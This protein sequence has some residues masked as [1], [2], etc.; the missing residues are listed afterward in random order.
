MTIEI[1]DGGLTTYGALLRRRIAGRIG[2]SFAAGGMYVT[3]SV[4]DTFTKPESYRIDGGGDD[5]HIT[6]SDE[7]GLYY[8]IGKFLHSACWT[9]ESFTPHATDGWVSPDCPFRCIY[10][11]V[12]F[13]NWYHRATREELKQY[14]E[15]LMLYG[16]NTIA[17]I[18]PVLNIHSFEEPLY[19]DAVEKIRTVYA[20]AKDVGM[21]TMF[22]VTPNQ[23]LLSAPHDWDADLSYD[24]EGIYRGWLGRNLCPNKPGA[25]EYLRGIWLRCLEQFFDIGIDYVITC[26]YDEGGCGCEKCKPWGANGFETLSRL[27]ARDVKRLYPDAKFIYSTWTFDV[28]TD[29]QEYS[30]LYHRLAAGEMD[31]VDYLMTDA[32]DTYP[33]YVLEHPV[34]RP[35]VNFPEISMWKLWPWGGFGATPMPRRFEAIWDSAKAVLSGG[36]PYTE[37]LYE[38]ISKIQ[39]IGYY[40]DKNARYTD[41][42][43]EYAAYQFGCEVAEDAVRLMELIE[44]N[45]VRVAHVEEPDFAAAEQAWKLAQSIDVRMSEQCKTAWRWRVLYIR[46]VLDGKRYAMYRSLGMHGE[47]DLYALRHDTKGKQLLSHD[48]EAQA[49]YREL[50]EIYHCVDHDNGSNQ[51]TLPVVQGAM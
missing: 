36:M 46:A 10:F 7:R 18:V 31:Y 41:I 25:V 13:Y 33:R 30:T 6:G 51:W 39:F 50:R 22:G 44:E 43:R 12:H 47:E 26:P 34:I 29:Q 1:K 14:L 37:G 38:D 35:I 4:D 20:T 8:G 19:R 3:L 23:G 40:W 5:W 42:L 45:H 28:P 17:S 48:G 49:L 11:A 2:G 21:K 27:L 15:D 24:T 9:E 16:Y 32:H